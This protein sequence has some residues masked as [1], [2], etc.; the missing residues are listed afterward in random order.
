MAQRPEARNQTAE[1]AAA[2]PAARRRGG[3]RAGSGRKPDLEGRT[4]VLTVDPA[5]GIKLA[6]AAAS[7]L[8]GVG[9]AEIAVAVL[10]QQR[11]NFHSVAKTV[12]KRAKSSLAIAV[13]RRDSDGDRVEVELL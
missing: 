9:T 12:A 6:L 5:D 10:A 11:H 1:G 8:T 7:N 13:A 2:L 4:L 3:R